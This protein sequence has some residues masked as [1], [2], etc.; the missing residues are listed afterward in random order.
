MLEAV[1]EA[2]TPVLPV[3]FPS[4]FLSSLSSL[5]YPFFQITFPNGHSEQTKMPRPK[6][7]PQGVFQYPLINQLYSG[8]HLKHI[9]QRRPAIVSEALAGMSNSTL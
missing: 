4:S 6:K 1:T 2:V 9:S 7:L 8:H 5:L 3:C